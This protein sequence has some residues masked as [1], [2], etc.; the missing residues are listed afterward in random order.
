MDR[1]PDRL[2]DAATNE[3]AAKMRPDDGED[4]DGEK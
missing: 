3:D 4:E 1:R 2:D